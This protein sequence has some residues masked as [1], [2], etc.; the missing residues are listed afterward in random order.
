MDFFK[1]LFPFFFFCQ[2][3]KIYFQKVNICY[4]LILVFFLRNHIED[5]QFWIKEREKKKLSEILQRNKYMKDLEY[6]LA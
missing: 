2:T 6:K 1:N 3:L 4:V 5:C